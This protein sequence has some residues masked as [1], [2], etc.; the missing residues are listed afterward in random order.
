[1]LWM[2]W[3]DDDNNDAM[4]SEVSTKNPLSSPQFDQPFG[5]YTAISLMLVDLTDKRLLVT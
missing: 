5:I 4:P 1:M 2:E 3:V